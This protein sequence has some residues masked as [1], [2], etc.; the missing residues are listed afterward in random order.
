[1]FFFLMFSFFLF[2][3]T[4]LFAYLTTFMYFKCLSIKK[5]YLFQNNNN[6]D[7]SETIWVWAQ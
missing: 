3:N 4:N 6:I 2:F 7:F 5:E 1:M